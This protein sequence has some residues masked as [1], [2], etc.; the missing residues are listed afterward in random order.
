MVQLHPGEKL[1]LA[2]IAFAGLAMMLAVYL[3]PTEVVW[4]EFRAGFLFSGWIVLAGFGLRLLNWFSK[5]SV[6]LVAVGFF[7]IYA[8]A[9]ALAAYMVFP[10]SRPLIDMQLMAMDHALGYDWAQAVIWLADYPGL[11]DL[12]RVVYLSSMPQLLMLL[13]VLGL[14]GRVLALHRMLATGMIAGI[15]TYAFWMLFPSFGP[16][17]YQ[18]LPA[19]VVAV[20]GLLASPDYG[21]MLMDLALNGVERI[22]KH[23]LLGTVA[24]PSFHIFM[25]LLAVWFAR[26]TALFW[27]Y[28]LLNIIIL[29][30]TLT[31]GGHHLVDVPAGALVFWLAYLLVCK[32]LPEREMGLRHALQGPQLSPEQARA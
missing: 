7:P 11:A 28:L 24:F 19:E 23:K 3:S 8:N 9:A 4:D 13:I 31:H 12:M 29:P 6:T 26:G 32:L 30:A 5:I 2:I 17:A 14:M 18:S 27:P 15:M 22:E 21:A 25:A 20:T 16:S 1:C 10:L